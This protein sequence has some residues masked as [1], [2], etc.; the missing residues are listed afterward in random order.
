MLNVGENEIGG[1]GAQHLADALQ[2][3]QVTTL[4]SHLII[5]SLFHT[6]THYT[7]P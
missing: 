4:A 2:Q 3:N 5:Q 7:A 6:D 1:R